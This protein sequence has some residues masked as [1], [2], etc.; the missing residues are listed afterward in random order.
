M[1]YC[2]LGEFYQSFK[3]QAPLHK[4]KALYW[5]LS[6]DGSGLSL[7]QCVFFEKKS[8]TKMSNKKVV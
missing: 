7:C 1:K 3:C 4:R 8:A 2:E 6:G 5:R